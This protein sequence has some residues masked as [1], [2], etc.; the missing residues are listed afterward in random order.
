M[1]KVFRTLKIKS[2][3]SDHVNRNRRVYPAC[4]KSLNL[5]L[6]DLLRWLRFFLSAIFSMLRDL[7]G[8]DRLRENLQFHLDPTHEWE[9]THREKDIIKRRSSIFTPGEISISNFT[10][11]GAPLSFSVLRWSSKTQG[12]WEESQR[13]NYFCEHSTFLFRRVENSSSHYACYYT[14]MLYYG[15]MMAL[16]T[17]STVN[18][19]LKRD[20]IVENYELANK[21]CRRFFSH[22]C[23]HSQKHDLA[24]L[25]W[26]F[27]ATYIFLRI[28]SLTTS[29]SDRFDD[30]AFRL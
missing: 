17:E 28:F 21:E 30:R 22:M 6:L 5:L 15:G 1:W 13:K 14:H 10:L 23:K 19:P 29:K 24:T 16:K 12:G 25:D 18:N 3:F 7:E 9:T 2:I 26:V 27:R 4:L 11:L 8:V 20:D